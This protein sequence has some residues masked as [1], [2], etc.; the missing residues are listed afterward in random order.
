[1]L[2][3]KEGALEILAPVRLLVLHRWRQLLDLSAHLLAR[4]GGSWSFTSLI[5]TFLKKK[6]TKGHFEVVTLRMMNQF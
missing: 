5:S 3:S 4:D 6:V 1:V 2:P